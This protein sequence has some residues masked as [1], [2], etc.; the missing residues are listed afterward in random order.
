MPDTGAKMGK[1]VTVD[2]IT[3][4]GFFFGNSAAW[5]FNIGRETP[6]SYRIQ[7]RLFDILNVYFYFM[8][9]NSG[10][11]AGAGVNFSL[12]KSFGPLKAEL[13]AYMDTKG[14]IAFR[15]KQIG[16][17]IQMGGTVSLKCCG[18]GFS[19]SASA[20]LA[21]EAPKP[22]IITGE[23]EVCVKVLKK[24][25]CA[26]FELTWNFDSSLDNSRNPI[27][28]NV[29]DGSN[30][31]E[32]ADL[33]K[34]AKSNHMVTGET[35][36]LA[37]KV[38]YD[39]PG[40]ASATPLPPPGGVNG[41]IVNSDL[42]DYRVPVDT[43]IDI[44]FKKGLH[45][46]GSG[47]NLDKLGGISSPSEYIDY[48]P[49]QQGKSDRV[50]HKY[51]FESIEIKYWDENAAVPKWEDY[52]FYNALL[53]MFPN[54]PNTVGALIDQTTLQNMKWGLLAAAKAGL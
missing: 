34:A 12:K 8:I 50:R 20:T 22:H 53:P 1:L 52:D 32:E 18:I 13:S 41:W 28:G 27:L 44:E 10:I 3:E 30:A 48:V 46:T 26:R 29:P 23:F 54:T 4:L 40:N 14:R 24:E 11:R 2:G 25:R 43:F 47:G 36:N 38:L 37:V 39:G 15:P 31:I 42:D 17:A 49:P 5:Y 19:V 51:F 9:S 21:A 45:V 16:G 7:A 35:L 33:K 6:D